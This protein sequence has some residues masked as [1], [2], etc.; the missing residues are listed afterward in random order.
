MSNRINKY[1]DL[2]VW[3]ESMKLATKL[4]EILKGNN[5]FSMR[6]QMQRAVVSIPSNIAEGYERGYNKE[7]IRF[8]NIAKGSCGELRTQLHIAINISM[9]DKKEGLNLI[10]KTRYISAMIHNLIKR[11]K[12]DF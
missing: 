12:S 2:K 11:R 7:F 5:N 1:E 4:H 8:L 10:D 6:D 3:Q 9:I